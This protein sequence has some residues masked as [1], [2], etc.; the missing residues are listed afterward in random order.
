[1]AKMNREQEKAMFAKLHPSPKLTNDLVDLSKSIDSL[2]Q[3][4]FNGTRDFWKEKIIELKAT[5]ELIKQEK[6]DEIQ[7]TA[8]PEPE[9]KT[10][11]DRLV[12]ELNTKFG[13]GQ[14]DDLIPIE[15]NRITIT[16]QGGD[17]KGDYVRFILNTNTLD[18]SS[19]KIIESLGFHFRKQEDVL[20]NR[21]LEFEG[22]VKTS[23][24]R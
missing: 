21:T 18:N 13:K 6:L 1:M 4:R 14:H 17:P 12:K 7:S 2:E 22:V 11:K 8:V 23:Q 3:N 16:T 5:A 15:T 24:K 9:G 19:R 10:V 20:D